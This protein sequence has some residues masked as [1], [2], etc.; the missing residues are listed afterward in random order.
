[1]PR[2]GGFIFIG[3][4]AGVLAV[5]IYNETKMTAITV[6]AFIIVILGILDDKYQLSAKVKFS[7][8]W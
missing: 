7:S 5:S 8:S 2:M 6:G 1:M 4:A 3:V